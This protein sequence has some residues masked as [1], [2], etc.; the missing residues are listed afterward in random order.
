MTDKDINIIQSQRETLM[1]RVIRFS[2][3]KTYRFIEHVNN[4]LDPHA[5]IHDGALTNN[6][7][8]QLI[9]N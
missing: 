3:E 7:V 4:P 5:I 6:D 9:S 1:V 2:Q 8:L